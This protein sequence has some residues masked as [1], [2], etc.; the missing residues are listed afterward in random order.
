MGEGGSTGSGAGAPGIS[1]NQPWRNSGRV[2]YFRGQPI[3]GR[4][5]RLETTSEKNIIQPPDTGKWGKRG[6]RGREVAAPSLFI[7]KESILPK[8]GTGS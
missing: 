6:V 2:R 5:R 3:K 8:I 4:M 7:V 1:E